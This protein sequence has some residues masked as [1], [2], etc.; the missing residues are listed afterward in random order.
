MNY[1]FD[2]SPV[3]SLAVVGRAQRFPVRRIFCVGRNYSAQTREM[4]KDSERD[5]P[6]F[7][8]K[9]NDALVE[10]GAVLPFPPGT[11]N[12]QFEGELVAAIGTAGFDISQSRALEHIWGYAIGNDLTRRDLQLAAREAGQPW[13]MGKAF[14]RSAVV[15]PVHPV[16]DVGHLSKG[17]IR[18]T[19]NGEVRQEADLSEL[20]WTVPEI[21]ALLSQSIEL[22]PGDLIMTGTPAGVGTLAPGDTCVTAIGGLGTMSF[23]MKL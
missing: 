12:L 2:P 11:K 18:L 3:T 7:F 1:V 9:P 23:S 4:G 8:T 19:L 5:A 6:F 14:D 15:G 17:S 20:I 21:I 13:D 10:E 16:S 22:R